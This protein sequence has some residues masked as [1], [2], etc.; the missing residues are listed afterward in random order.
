MTRLEAQLDCCGYFL[1]PGSPPGS[2]GGAKASVNPG[3]ARLFPYRSPKGHQR[4]AVLLPLGSRHPFCLSLG[5]A[6]RQHVEEILAIQQEALPSFA[7]P[8]AS[9]ETPRTPRLAT[10]CWVQA[11]ARSL[12][13]GDGVTMEGWRASRPCACFTWEWVSPTGAGRRC[14]VFRCVGAN[15]EDGSTTSR[16]TRCCSP[17]RLAHCGISK[18]PLPKRSRS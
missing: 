6:V 18:A 9:L 12:A 10:G 17:R 1:P 7:H 14:A 13:L 5:H 3:L 16:S 11:H 15:W 4:T 2:H 8:Q